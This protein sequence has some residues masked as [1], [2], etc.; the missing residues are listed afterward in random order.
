[1]K[2]SLFI[3]NGLAIWMVVMLSTATGC[4][5]RYVADYDPYVVEDVYAISKRVDVF[6]GKLIE[7]PANGRAYLSFRDTYIDVEADLRLLLR[8]NETRPLNE[9]TTKQINVTLNLWLDDK[10]KHEEKNTVSNFIAKKHREQFG[11]L[12]VAIVKGEIAKNTLQ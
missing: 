8:R 4:T 7:T 11:R 5:Y 2:Y 10:T 1:M 9:E 12:F 3:L 6:Y